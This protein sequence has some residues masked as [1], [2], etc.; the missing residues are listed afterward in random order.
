MNSPG[1]QPGTPPGGSSAAKVEKHCPEAV[2]LKVRF[3]R[4]YSPQLV[5][6][7]ALG[8]HPHLLTQKHGGAY[9]SSSMVIVVFKSSPKDVF[10]DFRERERERH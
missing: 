4:F 5:K 6:N 7:T 1:V 8:P 2:V 3:C 9:R 10:I